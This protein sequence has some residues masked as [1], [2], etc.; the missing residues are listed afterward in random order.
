MN[1]F[2]KLCVL[3][4]YLVGSACSRPDNE[5]ANETNPPA[6]TT[7]AMTAAEFVEYA[8]ARIDE[9]SKE[10][11]AAQWVYATYI[12]D[13]TAILSTNAYSRYM[14]LEEQL[15]NQARTYDLSQVF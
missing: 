12:N 14:N 13:D 4:I 7:P 5:A 9:I 11:N 2:L 15:L 8:D 10:F 1:N 3:V 6:N